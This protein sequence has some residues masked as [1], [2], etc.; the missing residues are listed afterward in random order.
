MQQ[1]IAIEVLEETKFPKLTTFVYNINEYNCIRLDWASH[2]GGGKT[3]LKKNNLR[4]PK[5]KINYIG[6]TQNDRLEPYLPDKDVLLVNIYHLW[7]HR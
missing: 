6:T 4:F 7:H 2:T 5:I 1:N 3:F